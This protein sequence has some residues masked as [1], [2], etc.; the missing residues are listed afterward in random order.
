MIAQLSGRLTGQMDVDSFPVYFR[1]E[2][3]VPDNLFRLIAARPGLNL[4]LII[5]PF[6]AL[7]MQP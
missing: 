5:Q 4:N 2:R 6:L 1:L 3:E 7:D